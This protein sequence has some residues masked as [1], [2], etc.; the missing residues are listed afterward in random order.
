ME[1]NVRHLA[2]EYES[3]ILY[4]VVVVTPEM[5]QRHGS[6]L[7]SEFASSNVS[8]AMGNGHGGGSCREPP[9]AVAPTI[10]D[11]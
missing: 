7:H 11:I 2:T 1:S 3:G 10:G 6:T 8:V 9:S 4:S 5:T